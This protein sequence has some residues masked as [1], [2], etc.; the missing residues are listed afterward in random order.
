MLKYIPKNKRT[1]YTLIFFSL[2][3]LLCLAFAFNVTNNI[4]D[5]KKKPQDSADFFM[6]NVEYTQFDNQGKIKTKIATPY[7]IHY[8]QSKTYTFDQPQLLMHSTN[9]KQWHITADQ[10][11]GR[12]DG[13]EIVLTKNVNLSQYSSLNPA[14]Q[15][16]EKQQP[17]VEVLT[18]QANIFPHEDLAY[19]TQPLTISQAGMTVDA[20][21]AKVD[22]KTSTIKLLSKVQG[23]T[24]K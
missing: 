12:N 1:L 11:L 8:P 6:K 13:G 15:Q 10:G 3:I 16:A 24:T 7:V 23:Q 2:A 18:T 14:N 17:L 21:G 5:N 4:L 9:G 22:L 19:T 20:I